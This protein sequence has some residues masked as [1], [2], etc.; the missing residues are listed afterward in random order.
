MKIFTQYLVLFFFIAIISCVPKDKSEQSIEGTWKS[1]GCGWILQI[2]DSTKYS[3]YDITPVSCLP[4]N[5]GDLNEIKESLSFKNDTLFMLKGVM[6]HKFTKIEKTPSI[7]NS[8]LPENKKK[9]PIYNFEVFAKTVQEHYAF[10]ELNNLNWKEVYELQKQKLG[11]T[12]SEIELYKVIEETLEL[13]NDNHAYLEA[14]EDIYEKL[15]LTN[16]EG[17][18]TSGE[19]FTEIGDFEI[20]NLVSKH[21][22][23][24]DMTEESW[25]INWGKMK[26]SIGYIQIKSM[27]L[28]ADLNIPKSLIKELGYV[29]AYVKTFHQM[30]EGSYI[31]KEVEG[32]REIM[33]KVMDDLMNTKSI[34]IDLRFNG[35]GQDAVNFEILKRFNDQRR[36]IVTTKL[37]HKSSFSSILP[38][39][40]EASSNPYTKPVFVLT[41]KQTGS[42]AEAF[43]IGSMAMPHLKRIGT[44]TQGALSTALEKKLPNSWTFSISNEIYMDNHGNSYENIGVPIDYALDYSNDRQ[45]LFK[46]IAENLDADKES[47][48]KAI[49]ELQ[50]NKIFSRQNAN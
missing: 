22:I 42:A 32:V 31:K 26:D 36:Q 37:K 39:Y 8:I 40:I 14:T 30:D 16:G 41:S 2:Q 1:I 34:V 25:L 27:W 3:F 29:D 33:D 18:E 47:I 45:T 20:A 24:E 44:T 50:N 15:E 43:A 28:Y 9:D 6:T 7:C 10:M 49:K 11:I 46:N 13:L 23:T 19:G 17:S 38:I 21:H 35:G 5:K 12:A 48:L 4:S